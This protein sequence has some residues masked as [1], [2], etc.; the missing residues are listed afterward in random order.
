MILHLCKL[1]LF[2]FSKERVV[3]CYFFRKQKSWTI[4]EHFFL[5]TCIRIIAENMGVK[6]ETYTIY[7][8]DHIL[9][10]KIIYIE[11]LQTNTFENIQKHLPFW[12]LL[13]LM[14]TIFISSVRVSNVKFGF[15]IINEFFRKLIKQLS[16]EL[17][18]YQNDIVYTTLLATG[19]W[20]I[21]ITK[22]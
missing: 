11:V 20:N 15:M 18:T 8:W 14:K 13:G 9:S 12:N 16:K 22:E 5:K 19:R 10:A 3:I 7:C 17:L 21:I 2:Y 6:S 1:I 4:N